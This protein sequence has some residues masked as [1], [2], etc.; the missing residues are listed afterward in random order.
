MDSLLGQQKNHAKSFGIVGEELL[1]CRHVLK[2]LFLT[3]R[4]IHAPHLINPREKNVRE[5]SFSNTIVQI[6]LPKSKSILDLLTVF[7]KYIS[8]F[9]LID[10]SGLAT[11]IGF[12]TLMTVKSFTLAL[13]MVSQGLVAVQERLSLTMPQGFAMIRTLFQDGKDLRNK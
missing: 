2:G 3:Q 9:I 5:K 11:M 6:I 8:E 13:V 7:E 12:Q 1:T 4:Q 10:L